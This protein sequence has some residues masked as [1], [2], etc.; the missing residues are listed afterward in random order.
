MLKVARATSREFAATARRGA[1]TSGR[2]VLCGKPVAMEETAT[3][4]EAMV[5]K[6]VAIAEEKDISRAAAGRNTLK[7]PHNGGRIFKQ[8]VKLQE[9]VSRSWWQALKRILLRLA[10]RSAIQASKRKDGAEQDIYTGKAFRD[11]T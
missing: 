1:D 3:M 5:T 7:R 2:I 9:G 6:P 10:C 8:R 4:A 11:G